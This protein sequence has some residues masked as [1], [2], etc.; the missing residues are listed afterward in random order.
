MNRY[1][2]ARE[3]MTKGQYTERVMWSISTDGKTMANVNVMP[4][5]PS[6]V[7]VMV[8]DR[9]GDAPRNTAAR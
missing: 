2:V 7:T 5:D 6:Q 8:F 9:V 3:V 1:T 4:E